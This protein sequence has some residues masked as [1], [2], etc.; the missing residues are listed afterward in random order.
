LQFVSASILLGT[1]GRGYDAKAG[2]PARCLN[3]MRISRDFD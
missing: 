1:Q 2:A 3:M